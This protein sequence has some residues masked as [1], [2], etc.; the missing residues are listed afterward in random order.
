MTPHAEMG[1]EPHRSLWKVVDLLLRHDVKK[2]IEKEEKEKGL[3]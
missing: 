3:R 2:K 1:D